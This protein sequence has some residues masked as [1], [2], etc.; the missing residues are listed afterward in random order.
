MKILDSNGSLIS[1]CVVLVNLSILVFFSVA[2]IQSVSVSVPLNS[3]TETL[4]KFISN[5]DQFNSE[6]SLANLK[7]ISQNDG[8]QQLITNRNDTNTTIEM[9]PHQNQTSSDHQQTI[10]DPVDP[11]WVLILQQQQIF[12]TTTQLNPPLLRLE[13][14]NYLFNLFYEKNFS[15]SLDV[16]GVLHV[17]GADGLESDINGP[18]T[19]HQLEFQQSLGPT[20]LNSIGN[21]SLPALSST[22]TSQHQLDS[23]NNPSSINTSNSS[24]QTPLSPSSAI[25]SG[26]PNEK[27]NA[28]NGTDQPNRSYFGDVFFKLQNMYWP[29]LSTVSLVICILGI[30]ANIINIIVLT[31]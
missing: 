3:Q 26:E 8:Q 16:A 29:I 9:Q 7:S 28:Q 31:R 24:N 13:L 20:Q 11:N 23:S 27:A 15:N 10:I 2:K 4:T 5:P 19:N 14:T 17:D 25:I 18:N 1:I 12:D 6:P 30:F 22:S 21:P